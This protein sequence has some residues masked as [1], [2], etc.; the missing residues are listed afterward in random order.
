MN[1][2]TTDHYNSLIDEGNDPVHD[3]VYDS[4]V[5]KIVSIED[6]NQK[7]DYEISNH[8]GNVN[9]IMWKTEA[10]NNFQSGKSIPYY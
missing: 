5:C 6:I 10:I 8:S 3:S 9:W 7:W 1:N 4:F 2:Q